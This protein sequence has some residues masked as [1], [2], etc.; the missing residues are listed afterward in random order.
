MKKLNFNSWYSNI[1]EAVNTPE[2]VATTTDNTDAPTQTVDTAAIPSNGNFSREE[3]ISDIDTIMTNLSQLASQVKEELESIGDSVLNEAG[4]DTAMSKIKDFLFAPKYRNMQKKVNKM[5]MN[6]LDMQITADNL[7][8]SDPAQKTKKQAIK[9]KKAT[10]DQQIKDLQSAVDDKA[11]DRGSYVQKV[12]KSEKIKGQMELVKRASGMEDDPK[13]KKDLAA[14]MAELQK[15]FAEEQEAVKQLKDEAD[16]EKAEAGP[17]EK[18]KQAISKLRDKMKELRDQADN[19]AKSKDPKEAVKKWDLYIQAEETY[20]QIAELENDED[21][22]K[23]VADAQEDIKTYQQKKEEAIKDIEKADNPEEEEGNT[24]PKDGEETT[25][26]KDG[27]ETTEPKDGE[28]TT[29]PKD[30]EE[31]TEPKDGEETTEPTE[32]PAAEDPKVQAIKNKIK[33]YQ[34]GIDTLKAKDKKTKEDQDKIDMLTSAINSEK[35]KLEKAQEKPQESLV[36]AALE[37]GLN[38]MAAEIKGKLDWQF[39][40]NSALYRKYKMEIDRVKAVKTLNESRY[41]G[42]SIADNFRKLLS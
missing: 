22:Q 35:Q 5:K 31:T 32:E 36:H 26:P 16:K 37:L 9:D 41:T 17:D 29:E 12:L 7:D 25:E 19:I 30:G 40:N 13:K 20:I 27:E 6:A 4:E 3:I 2:P 21:T 42:N 14:S 39:E 15:R 18:T 38:E 34:D 33:E 23:N 8:S 24:E 28:E 11:K 10:I 1:L